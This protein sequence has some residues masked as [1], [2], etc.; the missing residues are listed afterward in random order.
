M[1][2]PPKEEMQA[3]R[4][5]GMKRKGPPPG[6]PSKPTPSQTIKKDLNK[7]QKKK[8]TEETAEFAPPPREEM[9]KARQEGIA[10]K[11]AA[12]QELAKKQGNPA[13]KVAPNPVQDDD[14]YDDFMMFAD[15]A[16]E[17]NSG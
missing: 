8:A 16:D 6:H 10:R 7:E 9:E 2:R 13:E 12:K 3:A 14:D 1:K 15:S 4:A 11:A 5:E 17:A